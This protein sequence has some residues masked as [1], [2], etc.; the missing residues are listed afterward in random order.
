MIDSELMQEFAYKSDHARY[1]SKERRLRAELQKAD[2]DGNAVL[3]AEFR[4][5]LDSVVYL[6]EALEASNAGNCD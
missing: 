6:R 4:E 5:L 3:S 1:V 2:A